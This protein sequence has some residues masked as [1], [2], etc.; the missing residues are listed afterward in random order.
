M[1]ECSF[2]ILGVRFLFIKKAQVFSE[3]LSGVF[4]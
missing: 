3:P 2:L 4:G 1:I